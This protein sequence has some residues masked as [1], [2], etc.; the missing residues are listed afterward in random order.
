[1][2]AARPSF[3]SGSG[4]DLVKRRRV[5]W[6]LWVVGRLEL[7]CVEFRTRGYR[8]MI[9]GSVHLANNSSSWELHGLPTFLRSGTM[10]VSIN[11]VALH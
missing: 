8:W 6:Y 10:V 4:P 3:S 9:Q 11:A 1:M 5:R 7:L 2:P